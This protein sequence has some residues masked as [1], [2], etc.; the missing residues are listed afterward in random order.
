LQNVNNLLAANTLLYDAAANLSIYPT[1]YHDIT[2]GGNGGCGSL[3]NAA[4]GYDYVTGLGSP[5]ANKLLAYVGGN[6]SP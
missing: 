4:S 6:L 2:S 3:C 5:I 1:Y